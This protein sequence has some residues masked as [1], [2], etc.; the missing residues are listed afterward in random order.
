MASSIQLDVSTVRTM[1]AVAKTQ[2]KLSDR[3]Q[4]LDCKFK[5]L[6]HTISPVDQNNVGMSRL[7]DDITKLTAA[8]TVLE[9][10]VNQGVERLGK[11]QA[12]VRAAAL[13]VRQNADKLGTA[14]QDSRV[15]LNMANIS[16]SPT[17]A[18]SAG[19]AFGPVV[20]SGGPQTVLDNSRATNPK[21]IRLE[22]V[23]PERALSLAGWL[24]GLDA[25]NDWD[26]C[27]MAFGPS[28]PSPWWMPVMGPTLWP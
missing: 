3:L 6:D 22:E 17:D 18:A 16:G 10:A 19:S 27:M 23:M 2:I 25:S 21:S 12:T 14:L 24:P 28:H 5:E 1:L 9:H 8:V 4:Q 15:A 13:D 20:P 26:A 11:A 7:A